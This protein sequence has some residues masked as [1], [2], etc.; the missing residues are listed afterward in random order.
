MPRRP[1][2]LYI[3]QYLAGIQSLK[4]KLDVFGMRSTLHESQHRL[5]TRSD[6]VA[7][8]NQR[9]RESNGGIP[10]FLPV[11]D[12]LTHRPEKEFSCATPAKDLTLLWFTSLTPQYPAIYSLIAA[13][14]VASPVSEGL[15]FARSYRICP[16]WGTDIGGQTE[17]SLC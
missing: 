5:F 10:A 1:L 9:I 15:L 6:F 4:A 14:W 12:S 7:N 16:P 8:C 2:P 11:S 3:S 13:H 17:Q